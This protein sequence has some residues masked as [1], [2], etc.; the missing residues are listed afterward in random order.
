MKASFDGSNLVIATS[1]V[2]CPNRATGAASRAD[3]PIDAIAAEAWLCITRLTFDVYSRRERAVRPLPAGC[4]L[5]E[6]SGIE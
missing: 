5:S 4:G 3:P 6:R 1:A 2:L